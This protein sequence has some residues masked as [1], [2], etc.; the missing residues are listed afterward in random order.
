MNGN[1]TVKS[2]VEINDGT[3]NGPALSDVDNFG[4]SVAGIGDLDGDGVP[5][6]AAG[7]I[8]DDEGG[9]NR[10]AVHVMLMNGN[11]TVKGTV[12]I[13]DGTTNGPALSNSDSFGASIAAIGDLDGR[14]GA[15]PCRRR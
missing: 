13:N 10:G 5:D 1:G 4:R 6:L 14:R 9:T 12:E 15:G 3:T 7:A 11:G 8:G 2:T